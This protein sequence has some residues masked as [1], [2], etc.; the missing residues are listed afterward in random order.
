MARKHF[1]ILIGL[2]MLSIIVGTMFVPDSSASPGS[3][4]ALAQHKPSGL[5]AHGIANA[6]ASGKP[7]SLV[8][9]AP[10]SNL[11]LLSHATK[12]GLHAPHSTIDIVVGLKL[13]HVAKL[14]QFLRKVQYPGSSIYHQWL[15]PE[16]F[17]ARYGP[18]KAQVARVAQFLQANGIRVKDVSPN[19]LLIHTQASTVAYEHAFGIEINNYKLD[20]RTFYSTPDRPKLPRALV[21]LVTN[22][23]GLSRGVRMHPHSYSRPL[24]GAHELRPHQAPLPR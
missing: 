10:Q 18:T 4:S 23:L 16:Q 21:P 1:L 14:K 9:M 3:V 8:A 24:V 11:K 15:T 6:Q 19:R 13:R 20:G 17:T 22:V 5:T 2:I 7:S 12:I